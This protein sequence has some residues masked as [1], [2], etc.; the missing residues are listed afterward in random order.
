MEDDVI[1]NIDSLSII[2]DFLVYN[3]FDYVDLAGGDS[4]LCNPNNLST[5][6]NVSGEIIPLNNTRTA[7]CYIIS[8]RLA[9]YYLSCLFSRLFPVDW[10]L[11]LALQQLPNSS[12]FW[13]SQPLFEHGS[14]IGT[15]KSWRYT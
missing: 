9:Y 10:S 1:V 13:V 2:H 12:T 4:L 7:C 14:C 8:R 5:F 3:P 6:F 11:S 15:H